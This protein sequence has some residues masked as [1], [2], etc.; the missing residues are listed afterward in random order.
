MQEMVKKKKQRA[1]TLAR[2]IAALEAEVNEL[3]QL[4]EALKAVSSG[5][6]GPNDWQKTVGRF[7]DDPDH[8]EA[9]RLGKEWRDSQPKC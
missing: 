7:K 3:K 4:V 5:K 6:P 8:E 1:P 9:V 2:R